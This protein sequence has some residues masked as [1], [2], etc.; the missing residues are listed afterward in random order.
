MSAFFFLDKSTAAMSAFLKTM[1]T[2]KRTNSSISYNHISIEEKFTDSLFSSFALF[3]D[4][5]VDTESNESNESKAHNVITVDLV[6]IDKK[7]DLEHFI[8][9][10]KDGSVQENAESGSVITAYMFTLK[11][12]EL[13]KVLAKLEKSAKQGSVRIVNTIDN[14]RAQKEEVIKSLMRLGLKKQ[15]ASNIYSVMSGEKGSYENLIPL[16]SECLYDRSFAKTLSEAEEVELV[17]ILDV[18]KVKEKQA[19][20]PPWEWTE[21]FAKSDFKGFTQSLMYFQSNYSTFY[22]YKR[23]R[24]DLGVFHTRSLAVKNQKTKVGNTLI[25]TACIANMRTIADRYYQDLLESKNNADRTFSE[26]TVA[27][28]DEFSKNQRKVNV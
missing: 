1:L 7:K 6:N 28:W 5:D 19:V 22:L 8:K 14:K 26:L 2:Y 10:C 24:E 3:A 20:K 17:K 21:C 13:I 27:L 16:I 9:K 18:R 12:P 4:N 15:R 11:S 23:M 25:T